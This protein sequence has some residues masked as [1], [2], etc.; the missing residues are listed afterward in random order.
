MRRIWSPRGPRVEMLRNIGEQSRLPTVWQPTM[1]T[2]WWSAIPA[3][4]AGVNPTSMW[5]PYTKLATALYGL[6]VPSGYVPGAGEDGRSWSLKIHGGGRR[7]PDCF[8]ENLFWVF[9]VR[10]GD[11]FVISFL[12]EVSYKICICTAVNQ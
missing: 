1:E 8:S 9:F 5:R 10:C 3:T 4:M 12:F 11:V 6:M 7:G 2:I